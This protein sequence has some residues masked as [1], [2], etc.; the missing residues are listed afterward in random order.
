MLDPLV[1]RF[2]LALRWQPPIVVVVFVVVAAVFSWITSRVVD[3]LGFVL[4]FFFGVEPLCF[5]VDVAAGVVTV[6]L[7]VAC[8]LLVQYHRRGL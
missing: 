1:V 2:V 5:I 6:S 4:L 3:V 8:L 7:S